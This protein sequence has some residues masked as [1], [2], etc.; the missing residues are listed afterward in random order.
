M[1]KEKMLPVGFDLIQP[2]VGLGLLP[3]S[4]AIARSTGGPS[5]MYSTIAYRQPLLSCTSVNFFWHG[6]GSRAK[7]R[8]TGE[9]APTSLQDWNVGWVWL[10]RFCSFHAGRL[11][12]CD[13]KAQRDLGSS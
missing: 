13:R 4:L 7:A 1:P 5:F 11:M 9:H 3:C 8:A 6:R 12:A 2:L 10:R